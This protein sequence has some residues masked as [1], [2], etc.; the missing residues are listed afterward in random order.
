MY[1]FFLYSRRSEDG[2]CRE[3]ASSLCGGESWVEMWPTM[4]KQLLGPN[5]DV[6]V[7]DET[8]PGELRASQ[9]ER[10]ALSMS[11]GLLFFSGTN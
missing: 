5:I 9:R 8:M 3:E 6:F 11:H 2:K 10:E 1:G 4:V 7:H